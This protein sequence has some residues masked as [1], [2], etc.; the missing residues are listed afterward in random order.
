VC[1]VADDAWDE[2]TMTWATRPPVGAACTSAV[3]S[4]DPDTEVAWDVTALVGGGGGRI[5]LAVVSDDADGAHYLSKEAGSATYAPRLVVTTT[6]AFDGGDGDAADD[7]GGDIGPDA[8]MDGGDR[9]ADADGSR[10]AARDVPAPGGEGGG[11]G[12]RQA[13]SPTS[14]LTFVLPGLLA[15]GTALR[16]VRTASRRRE[17]HEHRT[18]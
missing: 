17:D 13:G 18:P 5:N 12:C 1:A 8:A 10:D 14:P 2:N 3:G 9:G 16:L 6:P 7:G 15:C 4:V 11:C